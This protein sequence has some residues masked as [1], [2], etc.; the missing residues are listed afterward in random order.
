M[1]LKGWTWIIPGLLVV[2]ILLAGWRA[3]T[4]GNNSMSITYLNVGQGNS[5]LVRGPDGYDVLI[6]GGPKEAGPTV[7]AFIRTQ[8]VDDIDV[9]VASH[10]DEDH[11]GGL[12]NVLAMADISVKQVFYNGYSADSEIFRSFA[13]AAAVAGAPLESLQYPVTKPWGASIAYVLNPVSGLVAPVDQNNASVVILLAYGE[14]RFLFPGDL[15]TSHETLVLQRGTPVAAQVLQVGHHGSDSST[16][17]EFLAAVHPTDAV[18]SV[19]N[20]SYGHPSPDVL[21]RLQVAG[22]RTWRTN[23]D[24]DIYLLSDGMNYT[25]RA[26]YTNHQFLPLLHNRYQPTGLTG[27]IEITAIFYDGVVS[28]K[29]PDEYVEIRN[30]EPYSI[31]LLGWTLRDQDNHSYTFPSFQID[32]G[33]I[34][35]VYTDEIHPEWCGLNWDSGSPIWDNGGECGRLQDSSG[36]VVDEYCY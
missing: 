36:A 17:P 14:Q 25:I 15:D 3:V 22:I 10:N 7:V 32:P 28:T 9:M 23:F 21:K 12:V 11:I 1:K 20:N 26:Q 24:G 8:A 27:M 34:C 5:A 2:L 33:Q 31:E 6:D 18:I 35:R 16:S 13:T 29:E 19:G 4:A 30:P